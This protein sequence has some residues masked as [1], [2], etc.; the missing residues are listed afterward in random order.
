VAH[1]FDVGTTLVVTV[2]SV[3]MEASLT[4]SD[5]LSARLYVSG[6]YLEMEDD[7][8]MSSLSSPAL[9]ASGRMEFHHHLPFSLSPS[10]PEGARNRRLLLS[11]LG[12][13]GEGKAVLRLLLCAEGEEEEA[14][15]VASCLVC[16]WRNTPL[17]PPGSTYADVC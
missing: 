3:E 13:A 1:E 11:C 7:D 17:I 14:W 15:E 5:P 9:P 2:E 8:D 6:D 16:L 10:T 12:E 4:A